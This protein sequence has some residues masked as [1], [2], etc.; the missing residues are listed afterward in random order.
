MI[1]PV[2]TIE[3]NIGGAQYIFVELINGNCFHKMPFLGKLEN[4]G[5]PL[6]VSKLRGE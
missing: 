2:S 1:S 3:P 6:T 4:I 5:H